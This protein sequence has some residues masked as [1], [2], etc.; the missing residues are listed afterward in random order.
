MDIESQLRRD[1]AGLADDIQDAPTG[2]LD[3]VLDG[4]RAQGRRRLGV[5][6]AGAARWSRR[7]PSRWWCSPG[8]HRPAGG[9][10]R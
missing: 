10:H 5:L 4:H 3:V 1:P 9:P 6:A 7:S 2:L 8:R